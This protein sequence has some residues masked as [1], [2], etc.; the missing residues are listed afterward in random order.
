MSFFDE[1]H[2]VLTY[3]IN[4]SF[5][6]QKNLCDGH[7]QVQKTTLHYMFNT[8]THTHQGFFSQLFDIKIWQILSPQIAKLVE[9]TLEKKIKNPYFFNPKKFIVYTY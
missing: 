8:H 3:V 2:L 6:T 4:P 9:F 7:G 5:F 1:S